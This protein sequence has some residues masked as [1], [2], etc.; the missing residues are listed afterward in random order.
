MASKKNKQLIR[1]E[2]QEY[3]RA[4]K[5]HNIPVT[6]VYLFGSYL[7]ERFDEWSDID[8]AILTDRFIGDSIDFKF[9]LMKIAREIDLDLE[10]HPYLAPDF[11]D[12]NPFAAQILSQGERIV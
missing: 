1:Q 3:V 7:T 2:I 9:L 11:N 10:P 12:S 4:L 5:H 6:A 8:I